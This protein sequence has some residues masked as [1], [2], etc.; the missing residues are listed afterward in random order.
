MRQICYR[1]GAL[2]IWDLFFS[3]FFIF[4]INLH[5]TVNI[6]EEVCIINHRILQETTIENIW[7]ME[8]RI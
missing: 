2:A 7:Y 5:Y 8:R 3:F 6:D 1:M 4:H